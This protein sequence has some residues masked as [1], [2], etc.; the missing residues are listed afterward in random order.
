MSKA[1]LHVKRLSDREIVHSVPI[2]NLGERH[3]ERV[4]TGMLRNMDTD[5]FFI[6]DDEVDKAREEAEA[7]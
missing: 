2:T 3:V 5:K 7:K 4:M 6:D 1:S